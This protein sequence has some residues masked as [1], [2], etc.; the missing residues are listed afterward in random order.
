M[1]VINEKGLNDGYFVSKKGVTMSG[2]VVV[3]KNISERDK[4]VPCPTFAWVIDATDDPTVDSG[5]AFYVRLATGWKKLY[6]T[7]SMDNE[8]TGEGHTHNNKAI[9]DRLADVDNVLIYDGRV[10]GDKEITWITLNN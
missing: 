6:E 2:K 1:S 3:F 10:V 8:G 5:S 4:C 9:L 7:E